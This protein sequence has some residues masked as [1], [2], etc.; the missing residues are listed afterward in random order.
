MTQ[1]TVKNAFSETYKNEPFIK[2]V[3]SS[4]EIASIYGSNYAEISAIYKNNFVVTMSAIDN[5]VKG[6]SGQAIQNMNLMF[7]FEENEGLEFPGMKP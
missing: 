5:L 1:E 4:P 2:I 7:G 3:D 6:A